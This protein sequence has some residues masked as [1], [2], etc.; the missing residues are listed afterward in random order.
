MK[1]LED[2]IGGNLGNLGDGNDFLNTTSK[3]WLM[4]EIIS[5]TSLKLEISALQEN[6]K[7]SHRL[8]EKYLQNT[9][10]IKAYP[11]YAKNS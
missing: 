4:K 7:I 1:L 5:W 10:L 2:N 11:K 9:Y 6:E 8:R 3:A